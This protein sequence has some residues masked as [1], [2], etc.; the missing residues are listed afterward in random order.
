M[1]TTRRVKRA[2][3]ELF[4][5]CLVDGVFDGARARVVAGRLAASGRR[6]ALP[7][8][9]SFQRLVRL[10]RDQHTARVESARPLAGPI[11]ER[12][13]AGLSKTYGSTLQTSFG[14]NPALI[15]GVRIK[16]GS[17]VYDGSVRARLAAL[18][19]RL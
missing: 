18:E 15:G 4:R 14:E 13:Q 3:R 6:G 19:S 1:K 11:R 7:I 16:V 8:L 5:F 2:A 12:I 17:D 10:D 9:S